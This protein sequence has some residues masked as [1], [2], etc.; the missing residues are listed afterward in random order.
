M[1]NRIINVFTISVLI[2]MLFTSG[3]F[4]SDKD[5]NQEVQDGCNSYLHKIW[6]VEPGE[7]SSIFFDA[8]FFLSKIE[9]GQAEGKLMEGVAKL[10]SNYANHEMEPVNRNLHGT[11]KNNIF[12]GTVKLS[13]EE[14]GT[15]R[16]CFLDENRAR[17][18]MKY[19]G[20]RV[21]VDKTYNLKVYNYSDIIRKYNMMEERNRIFPVELDIWGKVYVRTGVA[22]MQKTSYPLAY[23]TDEAGNI[24]FEFSASYVNGTELNR[25]MVEDLDG[26][27][28]RDIKIWAS[29]LDEDT[30]DGIAY[31]FIQR[32]TG[33]FYLKEVYIPEE[34]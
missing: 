31:S 11:L 23:L 28:L 13:G 10:E 4:A 8:S 30:E 25:V 24:F 15:V 19:S 17:L 5:T 34:W 6:I 3:S 2:T 20:E 32:E 7:D 21:I 33:G 18:Y 12:E 16:I 9:N 14:L 29:F 22:D 27:G 1:K 26:D